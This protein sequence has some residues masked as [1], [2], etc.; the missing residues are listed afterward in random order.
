MS[1]MMKVGGVSMDRTRFIG[2]S[3]LAALLLLLTFVAFGQAP[4]TNVSQQPEYRLQKEDILRIQ[5]LD[6]EDGDINATVTV[7]KDGR[8]TPPFLD[9]MIAEGLTVKELRTQ[10]IAL[11]KVALK[12]NEPVL[13]LTLEKTRDL[14]ASVTGAVQ[15]PGQYPIRQGDTLLGLLSQGGDTLPET[16]ADIRRATLTRAGSREAIP[17]DLYALRKGDMSQNYF[18]EDG[19]IL[20]VPEES[21]LNRVLVWGEVK[22]AGP[23]PFFEGMTV[24]DAF[25]AAGGKTKQSKLTKVFVIREAPG[26]SGNPIK[27]Q[28]DLTKYFNKNDNT[29]N[30]RLQRR[31]VVYV[32]NNGNLDI[33]QVNQVLGVFFVLERFGVNIFKF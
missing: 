14:R 15:R 30:I 32:T 2:R 13:S 22:Q 7:G 31:D 20:N 27:L 29:Q 18:I 21:G 16:K 28:V 23:V 6:R 11:Y 19:D 17:V 9:T 4:T 12:I 25:L 1:I 8:I 5:V 26:N 24:I 3:M 10:L 33:D